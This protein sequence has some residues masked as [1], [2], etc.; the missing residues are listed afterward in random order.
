MTDYSY[1]VRLSPSVDAQEILLIDE[2]PNGTPTMKININE[3]IYSSQNTLEGSAFQIS[4]LLPQTTSATRLISLGF[5]PNDTLYSFDR[6]QTG[7][8]M[9]TVFDPATLQT[10]FAAAF[11][12]PPLRTDIFPQFFTESTRFASDG[13]ESLYA[14]VQSKEPVIKDFL[15]RLNCFSDATDTWRPKSHPW[16]QGRLNLFCEFDVG[17]VTQPLNLMYY[18]L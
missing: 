18:Y 1:T 6:S 14:L 7:A 12:P 15:Y 10:L 8:S 4:H 2:P 11:S 17:E 5:N 16:R 9:T 3:S 13:T